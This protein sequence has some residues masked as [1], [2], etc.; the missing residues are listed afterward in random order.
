MV[1]R[2]VV[3]APD[4]KL[5]IKYLA[6]PQGGHFLLPAPTAH[7]PLQGQ[8]LQW[9]ESSEYELNF[10]RNQPA[11]GEQEAR[12]RGGSERVGVSSGGDPVCDPILGS[13]RL[14]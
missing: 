1:L 7:L 8:V 3:R 9:R 4:I 10:I 5:L 14:V 2:S 13:P 6:C 11:L 12:K